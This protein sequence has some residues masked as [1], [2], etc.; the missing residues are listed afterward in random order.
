MNAMTALDKLHN[1]PIKRIRSMEIETNSFSHSSKNAERSHSDNDDS[2]Q[3]SENQAEPKAK[4]T[5]ERVR[6]KNNTLPNQSLLNARNYLSKEVDLIN[7]EH[8]SNLP[9]QD[10]NLIH[11]PPS[12]GYP[13]GGVESI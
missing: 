11:L 2:N 9:R 8:F 1:K 10:L 3:D 4:R 12:I 13:I 7:M 6:T 5:T